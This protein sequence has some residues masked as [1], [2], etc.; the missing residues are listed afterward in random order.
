MNEIAEKKA[1]S[2][3]IISE[4]KTIIPDFVANHK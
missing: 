3:D 4:L 1:M 2:N